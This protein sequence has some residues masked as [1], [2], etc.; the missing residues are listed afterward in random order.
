V[1]VIVECKT[2]TVCKE[3]KLITD[4]RI[5]PTKSNPNWRRNQ[6][7]D[8]RNRLTRERLTK[9]DTHKKR[10]AS[11]TDEERKAYIK[12]KSEMNQIR[13]KTKPEALAKKKI[14]DKSDK[15]IYNRYV[16]DCNRRTRLVRGIKMELTFEQFSEIINKPCTYCSLS[17][18]RGVDRLDSSKSYTLDNVTPCCKICNSMKSDMTSQEFIEHIEKIMSNKIH[19]ILINEQ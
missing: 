10:Y 5:E 4:F 11:M 19:F 3:N 1:E 18:A 15:G 14:Y 17:N 13:F 8:C 16:G 7:D 9:N 12:Y 6:C 2:C